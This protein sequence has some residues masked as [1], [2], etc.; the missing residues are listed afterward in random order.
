[1]RG[2]DPP[3]PVTP[4]WR[5]AA[6]AQ[7]RLASSRALLLLCTLLGGRAFGLTGLVAFALAW[8]LQRW[9]MDAAP[10]AWDWLQVPVVAAGTWWAA[11]PRAALAM[12][13]CGAGA[14]ALRR[15]FVPRGPAG[16]AV[17]MAAAFVAAVA[18]DPAWR[19]LTALVLAGLQALLL[20]PTV[21]AVAT[22]A[23][24]WRA[25]P[26]APRSGEQR[27]TW[28]PAA[29]AAAGGLCAAGLAGVGPVSV[30]LRGAAVALL[31]SFAADG[32]G[33]AA[34]SGA[35]AGWVAAL[36][37]GVWSV[38]PAASA[39]GGAL[40]AVGAALGGRNPRRET[41]A[42]TSAR[43]GRA[44][45][46]G[47]GALAVAALQDG[48]WAWCLGMLL[49]ALGTVGRP[50]P[51]EPP[52]PQSVVGG[53][54]ADLLP[55]LRACARACLELSRGLAQVA[56]AGPEA[57]PAE[58]EALRLAEEVCPGCP[59]LR[60]CWERRLPAARRM[61]V[62]VWE[63]ALAGGVR[64]QQVGG[65]DTIHC[66]RPRQMAEVANRHAA[67]ARQRQEMERLLAASRR[68]A[69]S[70]LLSI[71]RALGE[72]ADELGAARETAPEDRPTAPPPGRRTAG[73]AG[74][75]SDGPTAPEAETGVQ[76]RW[77]AAAGD[78]CWGFAAAAAAVARPGRAVSGDGFRCRLLPGERLAL[79]LSDGMGSGPLAA[80]ASAAAAEHVLAWLHAGRTPLQALRLTN[81]R[82][83]EDGGAE[84]F[85]TLDLAVIH[86]RAAQVEWFKM[87]APPGFLCHA[88]GVREL[89]GGGLPA[90]VLPEPEIR[91][92]RARL[93]PGDALV[94]VSDGLLDPG[95][96]PAGGGR[97]SRTRWMADWLRARMRGRGGAPEDPGELAAA[98]LAAARRRAGT[99][100]D[101]LTVL[102]AVL[103][104]S[105]PP[106]TAAH[107][108]A[109]A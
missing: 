75:T 109:G 16:W 90:G 12:V 49:G 73:G 6:R 81:E 101:D 23:G 70:P 11:G 20:P 14:L 33:E 10:D 34:L 39:L 46:L 52:R 43:F 89:P 32:P 15:V 1:M 76:G 24:R 50:A 100:H 30:D 108:R 8:P 69:V 59:S 27:S 82:L 98:A 92:T 19:G 44:F 13:A 88:L 93:R 3:L 35:V 4:W 91:C 41:G 42:A 9:W 103:A 25:D 37:G 62:E 58:R 67:L 61:V 86:L 65:A 56:A 95:P 66:L 106:C 107:G 7:P 104:A 57:V 97:L 79:V 77:S 17:P 53:V 28:E 85:A 99:D 94:L 29:V 51:V 48:G 54:P 5:V 36:T 83:L 2:V 105:P 40:A 63:A 45:G 26:S 102:A 31:I 87:G 18:V 22:L 64:W 21:L 71:G 80:V 38:A 78:G 84:R 68:S 47:A 60:T 74:A 72:L 96:R 55:R